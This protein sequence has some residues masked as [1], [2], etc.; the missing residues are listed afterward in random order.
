MGRNLA[1]I[2]DRALRPE[3]WCIDTVSYDGEVI[4]MAGWALAPEGRSDLLSFTVN[5]R[6]FDETEFP[7]SRPDVAQIFWYKAGADRTGFRCR[8]SLTRSELFKDGPAVLKCVKRKTGLPLREEFNVYFPEHAGPELPDVERRRRVW[9]ADNPGLFR[10]EGFSTF[11]KLDL[12]L[13]KTMNRALGDF[14]NILD[15]GCGCGRVTRNFDL[16]PEVR[17][18]GI[19]IDSDNVNWCREHFNFG[20]YRVAPLHPPTDLA[21]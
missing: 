14:R 9:G 16:L 19:D 8:A 5:D 10:L 7:L 20:E 2:L 13:R 6:E 21:T 12:T 15:W 3:P 1:K 11:K 18:V 4:E 17:V